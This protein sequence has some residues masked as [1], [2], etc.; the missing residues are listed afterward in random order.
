MNNNQFKKKI[1]SILNFK[2]NKNISAK[3][4]SQVINFFSKH[5]NE[6]SYNRNT[7]YGQIKFHWPNRK[8]FLDKY[9]KKESLFLDVG[10]GGGAIGKSFLKGYEKKTNY[11]G[12]DNGSNI[13]KIKKNNYLNTFAYKSLIEN[14]EFKNYSFDII[15]CLFISF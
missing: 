11:I 4:Q 14:V 15:L 13:H 7:E 12:V 8:F 3:N 6:T 9:L 5:H 1:N 2:K 10:C